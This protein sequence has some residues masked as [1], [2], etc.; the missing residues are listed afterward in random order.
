MGGFSGVVGS[1][2]KTKKFRGLV[3]SSDGR[4]YGVDYAG[5]LWRL[6]KLKLRGISY[7][8]R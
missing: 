3:K 8:T 1:Q 7:T 6:D 4:T 2:K 5:T